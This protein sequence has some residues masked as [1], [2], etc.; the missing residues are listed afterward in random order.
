MYLHTGN[1]FNVSHLENVEKERMERMAGSAH[2]CI[3]RI[4]SNGE[5]GI[6]NKWYDQDNDEWVILLKGKAVLEFEDNL[7]LELTEGDYVLIPAHLRHKVTE[8]SRK[9]N[10]IWLALHGDIKI[11]E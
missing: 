3:E 7:T 2:L 9:P 8:A 5:S 11:F 4:V 1:F 6:N 10:C